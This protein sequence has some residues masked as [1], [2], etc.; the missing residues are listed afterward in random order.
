[1]STEDT[2]P[3]W[4][5]VKVK[6]L[7]P[8][9]LSVFFRLY[10]NRVSGENSKL[11]IASSA[12]KDGVF[13]PN[14]SQMC[15]ECPRLFTLLV[16]EHIFLKYTRDIFLNRNIR[17]CEIVNDMKTKSW[18]HLLS[19]PENRRNFRKKIFPLVILL[20]DCQKTQTISWLK[21][22]QT[23]FKKHSEHTDTEQQFRRAS[24]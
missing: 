23:I 10:L 20:L 7:L 12:I 11:G 21:M 16:L 15:G 24:R 13:W 8:H 1:M 3:T 17:L 18:K 6:R 19:R 2:E 9:Y 22:C 14:R 5:N 4:L